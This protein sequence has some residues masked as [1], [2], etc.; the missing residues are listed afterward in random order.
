MIFRSKVQGPRSK[1]QG[2][3]SKVQGPSLLFNS[4]LGEY[5][6]EESTLL[7]EKS[8]GKFFPEISTPADILY[9]FIFG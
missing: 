6:C 4:K 1:L 5:Y 2:P 7:E 3:R 8:R 9:I